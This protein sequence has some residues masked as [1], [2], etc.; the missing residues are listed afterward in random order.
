MYNEECWGVRSEGAEDSWLQD[1]QDHRRGSVLPIL[2]YC[3]MELFTALWF[4]RGMGPKIQGFIFGLFP[5]MFIDRL[6]QRESM[7]T[8]MSPGFKHQCTMEKSQ[9]IWTFE[10]LDPSPC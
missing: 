9:Q 10:F 7:I 5:T 8:T 4:N 6:C 1:H 3:S 2:R